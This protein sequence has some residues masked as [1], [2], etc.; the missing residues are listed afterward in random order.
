MLQKCRII[1]HGTGIESKMAAMIESEELPDETASTQSHVACNSSEP[2]NEVDLEQVEIYQHDANHEKLFDI[3]KG[4]NSFDELNST[5]CEYEK[6]NN[7][8]MYMR[9]SRRLDVHSYARRWKNPAPVGLK[10]GDIHYRCR[11]GGFLRKSK[12]KGLRP[13]QRWV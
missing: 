5:I 8:R 6:I 9:S 10:Y 1:E 11:N 7:I 2:E 4:F 13:K 3:G 12:S